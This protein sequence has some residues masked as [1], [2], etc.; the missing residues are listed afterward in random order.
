MDLCLL[1]DRAA[2]LHPLA[3]LA[4][5]PR[6]YSAPGEGADEGDGDAGGLSRQQLMRHRESLLPPS[7]S[8]AGERALAFLP[9]TKELTEEHFLARDRAQRPHETAI[10]FVCARPIKRR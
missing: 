4:D 9:S 3:L 6:K 5:D 2:P 7:A 10:R 8:A 1:P